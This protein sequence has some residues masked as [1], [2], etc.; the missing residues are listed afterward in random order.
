M[1]PLTT[2]ARTPPRFGFTHLLGY[3]P[4]NFHAR[5]SVRLVA[6]DVAAPSLPRAGVLIDTRSPSRFAV[7]MKD[8]IYRGLR[9]THRPRPYDVHVGWRSSDSDIHRGRRTACPP[10]NAS[11]FG[12]ALTR[13]VCIPAL[14]CLNTNGAKPT[15]RH[16]LRPRCRQTLGP[17]LANS[18][19]RAPLD[20]FR[21]CTEQ[22]FAANTSELPNR[23]S[24]V[25][26]DWLDQVHSHRGTPTGP[27]HPC[28]GGWESRTKLFDSSVWFPRCFDSVFMFGFDGL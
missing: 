21:G 10:H 28:E 13:R 1:F 2:A 27:W 16:P 4:P 8:A 3:G 15:P 23:N 22:G 14:R 24:E 7:E 6:R 20:C 17:W 9:H 26:T 25:E 19:L 12:L 11:T 5:R 18:C